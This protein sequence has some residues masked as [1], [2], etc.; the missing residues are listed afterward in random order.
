MRKNGE[1]KRRNKYY[2][3]DPEWLHKEASHSYLN[4]F[5]KDAFPLLQLLVK[6]LYTGLSTL[7]EL[8]EKQAMLKSQAVRVLSRLESYQRAVE[9]ERTNGQ[10]I[11]YQDVEEDIKFVKTILERNLFPFVL[12]WSMSAV[13]AFNMDCSPE[14]MALLPS[15]EK[16]KT[17]ERVEQTFETLSELNA[18]L[19]AQLDTLLSLAVK[20]DALVDNQIFIYEKGKVP[21][22]QMEQPF[23]LP[24]ELNEV[25]TLSGLSDDKLFDLVDYNFDDFTF[26]GDHQHQQKK[27]Q[28]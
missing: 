27:K 10:R 23:L 1:G 20:L 26:K 25:Y 15:D 12:I 4:E 19:F 17:F 7:R 11:E 8:A 3:F 18:K 6:Q 5:D 24:Q 28:G 21:I 16:A 14:S 9:Y 2:Y 22:D 13:V